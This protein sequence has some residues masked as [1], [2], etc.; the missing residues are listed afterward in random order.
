M[1]VRAADPLWR[2]AGRRPPARRKLS[3]L[4]TTGAE[5]RVSSQ[6]LCQAVHRPSACLSTVAS[7]LDRDISPRK[8]TVGPGS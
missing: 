2:R 1:V 3:K 7:Q 8:L 4:F 6:A 5:A